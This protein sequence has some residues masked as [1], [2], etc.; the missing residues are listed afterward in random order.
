[1]GEHNELKNRY[2]H[3]RWEETTHSASKQHIEQHIGQLIQEQ[4][5]NLNP[6]D[7]KGIRRMVAELFC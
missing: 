2:M 5:S 7:I 1:M 3:I 6:L 4:N